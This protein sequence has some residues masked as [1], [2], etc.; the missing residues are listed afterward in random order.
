M[1]TSQCVIDDTDP[2]GICNTCKSV[3][4]PTIHKLRCVRWKLG[5]CQL[6]RIGSLGYSTR[7]PEPRMNEVTD[8]A[9]NEIRMSTLKSTMFP[10]FSM[11]L[12]FRKF[13]P[14]KDDVLERSWNDNKGRKS[15]KI[16]PYAIAHMAETAREFQEVI[17]GDMWQ[18]LR[19]TVGKNDRFL[20]KAYEFAQQHL[21]AVL[22]RESLPR[23]L[24]ILL[25]S[26]SLMMNVCSYE[27][28][29]VCASWSA[30]HADHV[31]LKGTTRLEYRQFKIKD[32]FF[33]EKFHIPQLRMTNFVCSVL[34][35][36]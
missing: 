11:V 24:G 4:K 3:S 34:L 10:S 9:S 28:S 25:R 22:V 29:F 21:G 6:Y 12:R 30:F 7:W 36:S 35:R 26:S 31:S 18:Y 19:D 27:T 2:S 32:S 13:I 1:L 14:N 16:A 23:I 15:V 33:M 17:D 8:W 5:D 20:C